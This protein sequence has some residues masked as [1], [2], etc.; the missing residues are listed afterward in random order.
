MMAAAAE[1]MIA[2]GTAEAAVRYAAR[3]SPA[4]PQEDS[5]VAV[6]GRRWVTWRVAVDGGSRAGTRR[7]DTKNR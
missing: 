2:A 4:H 6:R 7:F 3:L 5:C 1:M